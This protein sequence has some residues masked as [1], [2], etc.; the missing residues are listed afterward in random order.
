[1]GFVDAALML[2]VLDWTDSVAWRSAP[3]QTA[4][5]GKRSQAG[6]F[7]LADST[8][9]PTRA[10]IDLRE[11]EAEDT[12]LKNLLAEAHLDS[13]ALKSVVGVER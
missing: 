9:Q 7:L 11:Q 5:N 6:M 1:M 3:S 8:A 13:H 10:P 2:A 12:E 4:E